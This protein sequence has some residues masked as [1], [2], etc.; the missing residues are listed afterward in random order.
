MKLGMEFWIDY[1]HSLKDHS[2][3]EP[4][5]GHTA[6]ILI[7]IEGELKSGKTYQENM[8]MDFEDMKVICKEILEKLDHRNLNE[9]FEFS[10]SEN[11][12]KWIFDEL[13][14]RLP[15][16]KVSFYEGKGKWCKIE[17]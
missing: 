17:K 9:L 15:V 8:I 10:T 5:H 4:M 14:K 3:C 7:E 12:T 1:A 11:I 16:C 6:K 13:S 2:K